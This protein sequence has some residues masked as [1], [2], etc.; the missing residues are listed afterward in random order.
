MATTSF[1]PPW[2][3]V[4]PATGPARRAGCWSSGLV[5]PRRGRSTRPGPVPGLLSGWWPRYGWL[6]PQ[7]AARRAAMCLLHRHLFL[8]PRRRRLHA[9]GCT[10][11]TLPS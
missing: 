3:G 9:T 8:P 6:R 2:P 10:P 7:D 1:P 5:R 11:S 4:S